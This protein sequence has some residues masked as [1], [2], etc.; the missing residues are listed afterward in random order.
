MTD[1]VSIL[2]PCYNAENWLGETIES[3]LAQTW[4]RKEVIIVDDGSTDKSLHVAKQYESKMVKVISQENQGAA[5]A[6]NKAFKHAQGDYIQWLDADDLLAPDKM[7]QQLKRIH[8]GAEHRILL[9]S[10]WGKFYYRQEKAQFTPHHL[11]ADLEPVE[12]LIIKFNEN[13]YMN[14]AAWL[15]SRK[16]SD[17]AGPWNEKL[18][19]DD[20]GEYFARVVAASEKITFVPEAKCYYRKSNPRSL[21]RDLSRKGCESLYLSLSLCINHLRSLEDSRRTRAACLQLLQD[22]LRSFYPDH[23]DILKKTN[24]LAKE[25]GGRLSPPVVSWRYGLA[26][27]ML[28][29]VRAKKVKRTTAMLRQS[30]AWNWDK[31]LYSISKK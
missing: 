24:D 16:L 7:E 25:L 19:Q 8:G 14:P 3:A 6:R 1:L 29:P 20:D 2:I 31:L 13:V 26:R 22:N 17:V 23:T 4:L 15:V 5:A 18:S 10:S 21:S 12:W 11:W 9:S 27:R 28:G 30:I